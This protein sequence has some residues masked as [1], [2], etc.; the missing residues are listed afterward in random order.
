MKHLRYFKEDKEHVNYDELKKSLIDSLNNLYN[1]IKYLKSVS[2]EFPIDKDKNVQLIC[3]ILYDINYDYLID[4]YVPAPMGRLI[5]NQSLEGLFYFFETYGN[6]TNTGWIPSTSY[7]GRID[8]FIAGEYLTE[9]KGKKL[10]KII[11]ALND[12]SD[13]DKHPDADF[14]NDFMDDIIDESSIQVE[15]HSKVLNYLPHHNSKSDMY[16]FIN[17]NGSCKMK[18]KYVYYIKIRATDFNYVGSGSLDDHLE[19]SREYK[20]IEKLLLDQKEVLDS[21]NIQ[22]DSP[23]PLTYIYKRNEHILCCVNFIANN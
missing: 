4:E 23:K 22:Y 20:Y 3:R 2:P 8:R 6:E 21:I 9:S 7:M 16:T 15:L 10:V 1:F 17:N 14:L 13:S 5:R 11:N 19:N 18:P 12:I